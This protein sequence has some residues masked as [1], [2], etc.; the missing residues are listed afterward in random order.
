M[1]LN[2]EGSNL[3]NDDITFE[4]N[5]WA[6]PTG[7][8]GAENASRPND[9]SDTPPGETIGFL[10][11]NN[12]YWNGG[13]TI[14]S[15]AGEVV[16]YTDDVRRIVADPLLRDPAGVVLPRYVPATQSF[17][18]GSTNIR[19]AFE[20]LVQ[21]YASTDPASPAIDSATD[22]GPGTDNSRQLTAV[23]CKLGYRCLGTP[24]CHSGFLAHGHPIRRRCRHGGERATGNQLWSGLLS[25]LCRG[26]HRDPDR[27]AGSRFHL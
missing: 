23:G 10:L 13:E 15:N 6:D 14:P 20:N 17:A 8:M 5:I 4:N 1:R 12:L 24:E 19:E 25:A 11:D 26:Q 9:F 16:N 22:T 18:D 3:P 21:L 2:V 7:T 27:D